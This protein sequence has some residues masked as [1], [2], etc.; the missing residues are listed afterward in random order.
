MT[1]LGYNTEHKHVRIRVHKKLLPKFIKSIPRG[2]DVTIY[3]VVKEDKKQ[4]YDEN[5]RNITF[6]VTKR[7][8]DPRCR[9]I[10]QDIDNFLASLS[11]IDPRIKLLSDKV[12]TKDQPNLMEKPWIKLETLLDQ[13]G[14]AEDPEMDK[15]V[16]KAE[17]VRDV[18]IK[19]SQLKSLHMKYDRLKSEYIRT[20]FKRE[21]L[22]E[23]EERDLETNERIYTV[24]QGE[25]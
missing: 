19:E 24:R 1:N 8:P 15:Y 11:D 13:P 20:A 21:D 7:N 4:Y 23:D 2:F 3:P 16:S 14:L 25:I 18:K 17:N 6:N 9:K 22:K 5:I 10:G 12:T